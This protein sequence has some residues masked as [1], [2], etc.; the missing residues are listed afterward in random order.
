MKYVNRCF[1]L[2]KLKDL[3]NVFFNKYVIIH[4]C[5]LAVSKIIRGKFSKLGIT[6]FEGLIAPCKCPS[7]NALYRAMPGYI[8]HYSTLSP[9]TNKV[10]TTTRRVGLAW[11]RF[12][13]GLPSR[14]SAGQCCPAN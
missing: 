5:I 3:K 11:R 14:C 9:P 6:K 4:Q 1:R 7:D 2:R 12:I 8:N 10:S 13:V